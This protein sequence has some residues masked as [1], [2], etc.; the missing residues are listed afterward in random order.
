[1]KCEKCSNEFADE[2]RFCPMCGAKCG[3]KSDL[4][5]F[6]CNAEIQSDTRFCGKCGAKVEAAPGAGGEAAEQGETRGK[7]SVLHNLKPDP[8]KEDSPS[9]GAKAPGKPP[10]QAKQAE[11]Q[12][13]QAGETAESK[14][15]IKTAWIPPGAF[16][17]GSPQAE[18]GRSD[19]EGPQRRVTISSGFWICACPVTQ[20]EWSRIMLG[21]PS[22]FNANPAEGEAQ[23]RRPVENVSWYDAIECANRLSIMEGLSPA[24]RIDG[25]TNPD[26]W[27]TAPAGQDKKWDAAEIVEGSDGWRLPTEAQWEYAARAGTVTAFSN[28]ATDWEDNASIESIGWFET[29]SER[30]MREASAGGGFFGARTHEARTGR[31]MFPPEVYDDDD[32]EV[33]EE[34]LEPVNSGNMTHEAGK[35]QANPWGLYDMH[36][37]VWEWCWDR[38]GEYPAQAQADPAGA[39]SGDVRVNRGGG[40]S[41]PARFA[42][43]ASRYGHAP[44]TRIANLGLRLV[45][46]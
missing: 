41:H 24:Y 25:S 1:M 32:D 44:F 27:G 5:C 12:N 38:Y 8:K 9:E 17:M 28:G 13:R 35:K 18:K 34:I 39:S 14:S 36:G 40:W 30:M 26:D 43:S 42:R 37:N 45:R 11:K 46:P 7:R 21:N 20:E 16:L 33:V 6:S 15:G 2:F 10:P 31:G 22:E 29:D 4:R 23:G 19:D 3:E